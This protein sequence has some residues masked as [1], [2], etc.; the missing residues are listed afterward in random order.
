MSPRTLVFWLMTVGVLIAVATLSHSLAQEPKTLIRV[1]VDEIDTKV[2]LVGRLGERLGK[3]MT[4]TGKWISPPRSSGGE[5]PK[6]SSMRFVVTH[7]NEKKLAKE[8]SF[9]IYQVH[10]ETRAGKNGMPKTEDE[11]S[12]NGISWTFR[13]FE[14]GHYDRSPKEFRTERGYGQIDEPYWVRPFTSELYGYILEN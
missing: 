1:S 3:M 14:S 10:A 9:N 7:V 13:A 2:V 6:D 8:V 4:V 12:L 5:E 11:R